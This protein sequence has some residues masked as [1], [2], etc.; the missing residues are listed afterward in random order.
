MNV[1]AKY[2]KN[3]MKTYYLLSKYYSF[4]SKSAMITLIL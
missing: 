1:Y 3:A 4:K 2:N